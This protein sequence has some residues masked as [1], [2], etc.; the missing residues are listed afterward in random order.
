M[1]K[2]VV[3]AGCRNYHN[4]EEAK[5]FIDLC[6][7]ETKMKYTII[8]LSG[9]SSGA[10]ALGERYALENGFAIE[11]YPANWEKYGKKAGPLRNKQMADVCDLLI[12]FWDGISKGT[13]SMIDYAK[14]YEKN[15]IIKKIIV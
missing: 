1:I 13:K 3:I 7:C 15:V 9:A 12:C 5:T 2:R 6:L 11:K 4:Y 8:I 14:K 10:D